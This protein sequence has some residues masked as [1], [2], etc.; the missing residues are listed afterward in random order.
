MNKDKTA[1]TELYIAHV[2]E[3]MKDRLASKDYGSGTGVSNLDL[4]AAKEPLPQLARTREGRAL[5]MDALDKDT[6]QSI[7]DAKAAREYFDS[8]NYS[9]RGFKF[10][11]ESRKR[12]PLPQGKSSPRDR[13]TILK[14][15]GIQ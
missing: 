1:N 13:A 14:Q 10:P 15:Y 8:N 6:A 5:I 4:L 7:E 9:L 11:S 12:E 3:L 2:A